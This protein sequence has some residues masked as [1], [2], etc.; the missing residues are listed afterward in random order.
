MSE[1]A[2]IAPA[3]PVDYDA[4]VAP[5]MGDG[6]G[7][8]WTRWLFDLSVLPQLAFFNECH[9]CRPAVALSDAQLQIVVD[10]SETF[11]AALTREESMEWKI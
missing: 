3:V 11:L 6:G 7:H 1:N 10:L 4:V 8:A 5:V 2:V 9:W